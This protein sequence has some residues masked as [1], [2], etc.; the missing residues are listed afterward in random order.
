LAEAREAS[1]C[2]PSEVISEGS[3]EL[4]IDRR[5]RG[6]FVVIEKQTRGEEIEIIG[7]RLELSAVR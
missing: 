7:N 1:V 6:L 5:R 2:A 3:E 4:L